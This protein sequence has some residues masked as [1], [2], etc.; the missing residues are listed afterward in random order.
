MLRHFFTAFLFAGSLLAA[1]VDLY[2]PQSAVRSYYDAIHKGDLDALSQLMVEESYIMT[3]KVYA[4][5]IAIKDTELMKTLNAYDQSEEARKI[6]ENEVTKKLHTLKPRK[7]SDLESIPNG[8]GRAIVR[9]LEA[10]KSKQL[11]LSRHGKLWKV[12]YKA[13]RKIE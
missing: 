10:G 9:Y 4:L 13:G 2:S 5:S 7:I 1:K 8:E 11:Y 3:L 6:V 12:D